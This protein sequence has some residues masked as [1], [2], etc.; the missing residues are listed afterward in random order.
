ML[1]Q[2]LDKMI[3][4]EGFLIIIKNAQ[5]NMKLDKLLFQPYWLMCQYSIKLS[6][7]NKS[8][9]SFKYVVKSTWN[10]FSP[11]FLLSFNFNS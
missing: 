9:Y 1:F 4:R 11:T 2:V 6:N 3:G 7:D 8:E 10:G 5:E